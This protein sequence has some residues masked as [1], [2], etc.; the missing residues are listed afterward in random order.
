MGN[1]KTKA[2]VLSTEENHPKENLK[3]IVVIG[4]NSNPFKVTV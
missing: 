1:Q 3:G 4:M 2:P